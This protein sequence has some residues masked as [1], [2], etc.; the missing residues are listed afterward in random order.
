MCVHSILTL[1]K[2]LN[3]RELVQNVQDEKFLA[4]LINKFIKRVDFNRDLEQTL[5]LFAEVRSKF[6]NI[7]DI[8]E[9]IVNRAIDLISRAL[10]YSKGKINKKLT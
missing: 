10:Q 7:G 6:G 3:Q 5:N 1:A 4:N 2:V 8:E 9:N